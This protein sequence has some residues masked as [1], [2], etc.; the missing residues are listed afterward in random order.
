MS[1]QHP[2]NAT[3]PRWSEDEIVEG[4]AEVQEAYFAYRDLGCGEVMWDSEGK[5]V[6][7]NVVR[8]LLSNY[9]DYFRKRVLGR[10]VFLTYRIPN[11][12]VEVAEK[13]VITQ[14]LCSIP[15]SA[16][17]AS[18][19]HGRDAVPVF[20][21]IL[22]F[23]T[24]GRELVWLH[25]YYR[26]TI[27][28][29][30]DFGLSGSMTVRQY[31]GSFRP[32]EV[33]VIP[34]LEDKETLLSADGVVSEYIRAVKVSQMRVF[35]ARSDPALNYG[36][37]PA[38]LLTKIALSKLSSVQKKTG[39][40]IHPIIGAGS[41]PF[42]GHLSP[43]NV[44]GFLDENKGLATVTTQSAF[45]YDYSIASVRRAISTLNAR[46]PNGTADQIGRNEQEILRVLIEKLVRSYQA[47]VESLAPLINDLAQ[48]VP[49]RRARKLH[50]GL[51]GYSRRVRGVTMPRAIPFAAVFYS[52]GIPP[53]FIGAAAVRDLD[54][55]EW[56]VLQSTYRKMKQD[57]VG[58]SGLV[59]W[60]TINMLNDS[61]VKVAKRS[62]V[63]VEKLKNGLS[64]LMEDLSAVEEALSVHLGPR[65][66]VSKKHENFV[67]NFLLSYI[68]RD[69][70]D[71]R[72][73]FIEAAG[74]RRCIG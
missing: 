29:V 59:S 39:V 7:T 71:A 6:D 63:S 27:T 24:S 74:L 65:G 61:Y 15:L 52:L 31:L 3:S 37:I 66:S 69:H 16:D 45:R 68:A 57:F 72:V 32:R 17:V 33:D 49:K 53:E 40:P 64:S 43:D 22:P 19:F 50:I 28:G 14:T 36:M 70:S 21:V 73:A 9:P 62:G 25:D 8:K 1:T 23:T 12:Q 41:M 67:N 44:S 56:E 42:R 26:K 20:E 5:D 34:L 13:K 38:V 60:E 18:L 48:Y 46:L 54:G 4:E 30:E 11:P 35:L 55:K 58:V 10:D 51:F 2:D 47:R